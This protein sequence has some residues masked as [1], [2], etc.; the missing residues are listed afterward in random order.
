MSVSNTA[1]QTYNYKLG[2]LRGIAIILVVIG[3]AGSVGL[4]L[5][6]DWFPIYSFHLPLLIFI[7]GYFYNDTVKALTYVKK[8]FRRLV[9][10]YYSW[11]IFY[12]VLLL[13]LTS[14]GLFLWQYPLNLYSFF[15]QPWEDSNQ[16]S[17]NLAGWFVLALFFI[18]I[19]YLT[20][21]SVWK[22]IKIPHGEY[23]L[24]LFLLTFGLL[25]TYFAVGTYSSWYFL[26]LARVLFGLPFLHLGY[27][28][29]VKL[30]KFDK[31]SYFSLL[32]VFFI[33]LILI[34][35]YG[36]ASFSMIYMDFNGRILEPFLFSFTGI[37]FCLQ[38]SAILATHFNPIKMLR[39]IGDNS[40]SIMINQFLGF[41]VLSSLFF[42]LN[43][44]GFDEIAYKTNVFY[45]YII[46]SGHEQ[47]LMLY[48]VAG[49]F[50]SLFLSFVTSKVWA[51]LKGAV[52]HLRSS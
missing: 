11:N 12:A 1:N 4:N 5:F 28:Y 29:K 41:W 38:L 50:L 25:S 18:Q 46:G 20:I 7:S 33:Q 34:F 52:V 10:P 40:W 16:Y 27:L 2:Y 9:I 32:G 37:W 23:C 13:I 44:R 35:V 15:L 26:I 3:H 8:R 22:K 31:T 21:R 47:S 30:E 51:F 6:S 24:F 39:Y 48:V 19:S 14:T 17:F 36:Q 45:R 49:I 42:L 43:P